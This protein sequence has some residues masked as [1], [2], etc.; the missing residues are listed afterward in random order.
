MSTTSLH[1]GSGSFAF[2]NVDEL[3]TVPPRIRPVM[4]L[5]PPTHAATE[6]EL[7]IEHQKHMPDGQGVLVEERAI[8]PWV[9][10]ALA[11]AVLIAG[12]IMIGATVGWIAAVVGIVWLVMGFAV[13]WSVVWGAGLLRAQDER[14][15]EEKLDQGELPPPAGRIG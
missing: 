10:G 9:A 13:S 1:A 5:P 7:V 3:P 15:V 8:L 12:A 6:P 14:L 4:D 11:T 2:Q